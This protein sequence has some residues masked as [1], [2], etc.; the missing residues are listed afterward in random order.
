[1]SRSPDPPR[2]ELLDGLYD[3]WDF[4]LR[5]GS[6]WEDAPGETRL[7]LLDAAHRI[8]RLLIRAR[9]PLIQ[10]MGKDIGAVS[11]WAAFRCDRARRAEL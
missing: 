7:P 6:A 8:E 3:T 10:T 11:K 5:A 9:H 4:L 2:R 1:M